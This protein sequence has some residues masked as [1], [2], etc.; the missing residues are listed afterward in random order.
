MTASN[1]AAN[2][3]PRNSYFNA[4]DRQMETDSYPSKIIPT[5]QGRRHK[6]LTLAIQDAENLISALKT[7]KHFDRLGNI[8]HALPQITDALADVVTRANNFV[9]D[10]E[11]STERYRSAVADPSSEAAG[12]QSSEPA[13]A[14]ESPDVPA[15]AASTIGVAFVEILPAIPDARKPADSAP[16]PGPHLGSVTV[17]DPAESPSAQLLA[18]DRAVRAH[19][20]GRR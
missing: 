4:V 10:V 7:A 2:L 13:A 11:V 17:F 15:A 3:L 19:K 8:Q 5:E 1:E 6:L 9:S 14:V 18:F 16:K 20:A 12:G